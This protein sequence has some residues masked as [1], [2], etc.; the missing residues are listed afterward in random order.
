[1]STIEDE[2]IAP[3]GLS[4]EHKSALSLQGFSHLEDGRRRYQRRQAQVRRDAGRR[5]PVRGAE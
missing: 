2:V 4:E 5:K 3:S 1:M